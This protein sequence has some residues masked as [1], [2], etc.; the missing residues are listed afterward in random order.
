MQGTILIYGND[1]MLVITRRMIFERA[2][3]TVL[4]A[5]NISDAMLLLINH[6]TGAVPKCYDDE[7][8]SI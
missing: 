2:G 7:R 5:E 8:R 4:T 3:Y 1:L 6:P